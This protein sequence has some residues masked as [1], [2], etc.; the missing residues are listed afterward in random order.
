MKGKHLTLEDRIK[1][2]EGIENGKS[3]V[4][5]A[6]TIDKDPTTVGK[7]IKARRTFKQR[8]IFNRPVVCAHFKECKI[9]YEKCANY[10]EIKCLRRDRKV[11]AC[12]LCPNIK[13]CILDKYFYRASKAHSDYLYTLSDARQDVNLT[14][15]EM[16]EIVHIIKPLLKKGQSLYQIVENHPEINL[17]VRTLY[18]YIECGIFKDYGIDNFSL[19]RKVSMKKRK[20][21]KKRKEPANYNGRKYEDYLEFVKQHPNLITTEMD[22][23]Y[24]N[25]NGPYIKTFMFPNV[26]LMIGFLH[27]EKTSEAMS[28][29]LNYLQDILGNDYYK[30][31]SLILTDRGTEF[32]KHRLFEINTETGELRSNIFYC[33]PQKPSQKPHVENNHTNV[34]KIIP[35]KISIKDLTQEDINLIFS[36]INSVPRESLSGKTPYEAFSFFYGE[37]ILKKLKIQKIEKDTVT[38]QPYLLNLKK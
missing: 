9:C 38:L 7:E 35:K 6:K 29:T 20:T 25:Q 33:D 12:N 37:D 32:E 3:K 21:L 10:E 17:S 8:N 28:S 19:R 27:K 34:R 26:E 15:K 31:F 23:V 11:G 18:T 36:H 24:N 22:T 5:I 14:S 13:K 4:D 2:Q 30:L 1:I 16:I